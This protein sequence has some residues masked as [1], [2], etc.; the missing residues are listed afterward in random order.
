MVRVCGHHHHT[1]FS[2]LH[3]RYFAIEKSPNQHLVINY[4]GVLVDI[5]LHGGKLT[6]RMFFECLICFQE[7]CSGP[8]TD[9]VSFPC[10]HSFCLSHLNFLSNC[11]VCAAS[12]PPLESCRPNYALKDAVILY[13]KLQSDYLELE[14]EFN[15]L[16]TI[17]A[18]NLESG[19][20]DEEYARQLQEQFNSADQ[21]DN[22]SLTRQL[23]STHIFQVPVPGHETS[24]MIGKNSIMEDIVNED[25]Q[26]P[27]KLVINAAKQLPPLHSGGV[28][29]SGPSPFSKR[30]TVFPTP[31]LTSENLKSTLF[32]TACG[33]PCTLQQVDHCC[34]CLD[35]RPKQIEG[36]YLVF[37]EGKGWMKRGNRSDGYCTLCKE[38]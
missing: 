34:M 6:T 38:R 31:R 18:G 32:K 15:Q 36:T 27:P 30:H 9:P 19:M 22:T 16:V 23:A 29:R 4:V 25:L 11:P 13:K 21:I 7:Y 33:H 14:G 8:L 1:R 28:G 26:L 10:G 2:T 37:N 20:S 3:C 17:A 12:L 35:T 24:G 5:A